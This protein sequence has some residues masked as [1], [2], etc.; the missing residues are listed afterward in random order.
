MY[1][2]T[3][4]F[5]DLIKENHLI[6]QQ[7][8]GKLNCNSMGSQSLFASAES[9]EYVS[10]TGL[11]TM[12]STKA[13]PVDTWLAVMHCLVSVGFFHLACVRL[14]ELPTGQTLARAT[15][16]DTLVPNQSNRRP[17]ALHV[18]VQANGTLA[19]SCSAHSPLRM[20]TRSRPAAR[21]CCFAWSRRHPDVLPAACNREFGP[22]VLLLGSELCDAPSSLTLII[23]CAQANSTDQL[24]ASHSKG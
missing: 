20:N 3:V 19:V 10:T 2:F 16:T 22:P 7:Q 8:G 6:I 21:A 17:E 18:R 4:A 12:M 5:P 1:F 24:H 9:S 14:A 13:L 23:S 11:D 15:H